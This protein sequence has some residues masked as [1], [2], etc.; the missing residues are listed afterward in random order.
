[1]QK[2]TSVLLVDDDSTTNYLN[3]LLLNN[4]GVSEQLLV[5]ENG[6]EALAVLERTCT[7]PDTPACPVLILLDVNMP[8]MG[9][10]AFLEAYQQLPLARQRAI[11]IVMLTTSMHARELARIQ[12][13]PI[14]G[15][16]SKPLTREKVATLLQLH[17]QREL[18]A[19]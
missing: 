13:L 18:P 14:A 6:H 12:E 2:L 15:L 5:A 17:F 1:M 4:L 7:G 3:Q 10:F 16:V 9:G 8:V 11:V 19:A